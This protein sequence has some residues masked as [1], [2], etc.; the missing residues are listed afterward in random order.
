MLGPGD[1]TTSIPRGGQEHSESMVNSAADSCKPG[2]YLIIAGKCDV[3]DGA[4]R[5][6]LVGVSTPGCALI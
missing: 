3:A 6:L 5:L 4:A 2:T 1:A